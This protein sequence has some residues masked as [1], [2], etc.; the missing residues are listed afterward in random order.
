MPVR[1][2]IVALH[3]E[4]NIKAKTCSDIGGQPVVWWW[5][6]G[7]GDKVVW[8]IYSKSG[9]DAAV[10]VSV[11][12]VCCQA[13]PSGGQQKDCSCGDGASSCC[14]SLTYLHLLCSIY[15]FSHLMTHFPSVFSPDER[16]FFLCPK[17]VINA[18]TNG[19]Q[20]LLFST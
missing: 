19:G 2:C 8:V 18:N 5:W 10:C 13:G 6:W 20:N 15:P 3:S 4:F 17:P 12:F 7:G 9:G 1:S 11:P 16:I 14:N